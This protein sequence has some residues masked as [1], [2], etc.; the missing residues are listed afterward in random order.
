MSLESMTQE[1]LSEKEDGY[2]VFYY[3]N[4]NISSEGKLVDGK[5]EGIWKSYYDNGTLKSIGN[6]RFFLLDSVWNF[7]YPDGNISQSIYYRN[8]LRNG[9][10]VNFEFYFNKDSVKHYYKSSKILYFN[11]KKEGLS[12]YY[13]N[14][15]KI[16][17]SYNYR[18]D[19]RHG[20]GKEYDNDSLVISIYNYYDGYLI[21]RFLVNRYDNEGKKQG[22][23][24]LFYQ[25]GNKQIE[26]HYLNNKLHGI[27]IEYDLSGNKVIEKVYRDGVIHVPSNEEIEIE[28]IA[29]IKS[30]YYK[31]GTLKFQ[32]AFIDSIPVG[33]HREFDEEGKL[34]LAKEFDGNGV[35]LGEGFFDENGLKTGKWRLFDN[36]YKYFYGEGSY[37]NGKKEGLW[38]Y[39]YPDRSIEQQGKYIADK[40][41][42]D[43]VWF[44]KNGK[45][46]REE[47]FVNGKNEGKYTEYDIN[48]KIIVSGEYFDGAKQGDW[49]YSVG[50]I[51]KNGSYEIDQKNG[52]WKSFFTDSGNISFEGNFVN[53]D[54]D[55][56]HKFYYG[57][58][59]IRLIAEYRMG[60]KHSN[61]RQYNDDGSLFITRT[62][63]NNRLVRI[64]GK[65]ININF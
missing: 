63:R 58:K 23:W 40:P 32:G 64:D 30:S 36:H 19:K 65:K 51:T 50:N 3:P 9:Y 5:P 18:N 52:Y 47:S 17:Y 27:Y 41:E 37:K 10:T 53:G 7:Y 48:G 34:L 56:V 15:S 57:N 38:T 39:Y 28:L 49:I 12:F 16:K 54:A 31:D 25:N 24:M 42:D 60:N 8:D 6:R 35:L 14:N 46:R 44:Y 45:V 43:W 4:G 11:G 61:W 62:F 1:R 22:K 20:I 13:D 59:N 29:E 26:K 55:G 33:I 2:T 21:E